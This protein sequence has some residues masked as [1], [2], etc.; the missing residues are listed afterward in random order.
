MAPISIRLSLSQHAPCT[1]RLGAPATS[2]SRGRGAHL[3]AKRFA[4][5]AAGARSGLDA[6]KR[7]H[8]PARQRWAKLASGA[9]TEEG[10]CPL[11]G[12]A[13]ATSCDE[14]CLETKKDAIKI[15]ARH[16][17]EKGGKRATLCMF[18]TFPSSRAWNDICGWR[19][20]DRGIISELGPG[21]WYL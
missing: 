3:R 15:H 4:L 1:V 8:T 7:S 17:R 20:V 9:R 11:E 6:P 19:S 13:C 10:A 14:K 12:G 16:A 18:F 21:D 5:G 2:A